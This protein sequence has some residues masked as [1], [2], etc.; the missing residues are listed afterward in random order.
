MNNNQTALTS[1]E[2]FI[3]VVKDRICDWILYH[4]SQPDRALVDIRNLSF[5][6]KICGEAIAT[7][8]DIKY[9]GQYYFTVTF[10]MN[11]KGVYLDVIENS[12]E[13]H[14]WLT[15]KWNGFTYL[16][17]DKKGYSYELTTKEYNYLEG[18]KNTALK[19]LDQ[20]SK[21][22]KQTFQ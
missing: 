6:K 3:E 2:A 5:T 19:V 18:A 14:A 10:N 17:F 12:V 21:Q 4:H 7:Y 15:H 22:W 9:C 16:G 11:E 20:E 8:D 1:V 13:R